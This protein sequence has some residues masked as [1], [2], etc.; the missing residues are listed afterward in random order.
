MQTA[1]LGLPGLQGAGMALF[2]GPEQKGG[3]LRPLSTVPLR[4]PAESARNPRFLSLSKVNPGPTPQRLFSAAWSHEGA[5][6]ANRGW[7]GFQGKGHL[8]AEA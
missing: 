4:F 3:M 8:G 1:E 5:R 2:L 7:A 6:S